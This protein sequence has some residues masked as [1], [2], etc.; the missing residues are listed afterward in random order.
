[1]FSL[2]FIMICVLSNL[3]FLLKFVC[4]VLLERMACTSLNKHLCPSL[5]LQTRV[6]LLCNKAI[7]ASSSLESSSSLDIRNSLCN[8]L[9]S[10]GHTSPCVP[11]SNLQFQCN[12]VNTVQSFPSLYSIWHCRLGHPHHEVLKVVTKLC[13]MNLPNKNLSNFC[14]A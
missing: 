8:K 4:K 2:S 1:M 9:S 13:N 12:N 5:P 11:N 14:S 7:K 10:T 3:R 6:N